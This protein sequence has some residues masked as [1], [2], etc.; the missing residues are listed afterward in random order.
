MK[1]KCCGSERF[2]AHQIVRADVM[3]DGNNE[4]QENLFGGLEAHIY[5]SERPYG[6]YTCPDCGA[7]YDELND[8]A[9]PT[10]IH[11]TSSRT[12]VYNYT[13]EPVVVNRKVYAT[14]VSEWDNE[15]EIPSPCIVNLTTHCIEEIRHSGCA[16]GLEILTG[17]YV[18]IG[19]ERYEVVDEE[20][21]DPNSMPN[22]FFEK[23]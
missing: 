3:V 4:F 7:E 18:D 22:A 23:S 13:G 15:T 6:P 12:W 21:Y 10:N 17:R 5:D 16:V 8:G 1:C 9:E 19:S 20:D 2:I 11:Q 14:Y